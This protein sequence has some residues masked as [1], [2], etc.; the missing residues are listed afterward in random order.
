MRK[1]L[2]LLMGVVFV[3]ATHAVWADG[4]AGN[5]VGVSTPGASVTQV[6]TPIT[7]HVAKKNTVKKEEAEMDMS[8][9]KFK[10]VNVADFGKGNDARICPVSGEE[11][12]SGDGTEVKLSNGKKIMLCCHH[13]KKAVEKD[14]K[15]YESL[16]YN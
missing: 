1:L 15:K 2:S 4:S 12:K 10:T 14:L 16:M 6:A 11:I 3:I 8:G 13:C 7:K 9:N 5:T